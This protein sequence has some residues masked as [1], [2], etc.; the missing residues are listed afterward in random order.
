MDISEKGYGISVLNDCKYGCDIKHGR[1][2][3]TLL[4]AGRAPYPGIDQG[5]H[6]F[7]YSLYPHMGTWEEANTVKEA[8]GLNL[9]LRVAFVK[10]QAGS[11]PPVYSFASCSAENVVIETLKPAEDN[12]GIIM[13]I[14]ESSNRRTNCMIKLSKTYSK[15]VRCNLLEKEEEVIAAFSNNIVMIVQPFELI[16]IKLVE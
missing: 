10:K 1:I 14:Y 9:P 2:R 12:L 3:L 13:R 7:T 5:E 6:K 4:K 15:I 16:T 11:L 8:Y